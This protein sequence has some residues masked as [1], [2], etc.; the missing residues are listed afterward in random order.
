ML[1]KSVLEQKPRSGVITIG[2]TQTVLTAIQKMCDETVGAL[3]VHSEKGETVGILTERDIL[4]FSA[5]RAMELSEVPISA[6]M[7][8]NPVVV[9]PDTTLDQA[10][11]IMT[12]KRFRHLPVVENGKIVGMVSIGDLVKAKLTETMGEVKHLLDYI[13]NA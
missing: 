8:K 2:V 10:Q 11:S 6:V 12:E 13:A 5:K 4:R 7:K 1:I 9:T 3:L